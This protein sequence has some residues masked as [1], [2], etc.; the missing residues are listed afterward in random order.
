[1][2][3]C[4]DV[5]I[6]PLS[7]KDITR[8]RT[9]KE[10]T[11]LQNPQRTLIPPLTALLSPS[12]PSQIEAS[13]PTPSKNSSPLPAAPKLVSPSPTPD[14][15]PVSPQHD[16][17]LLPQPVHKLTWKK[18]ITGILPTLQP[19]PKPVLAPKV[20]PKQAST[21]KKA[22][23]QPKGASEAGENSLLKQMQQ[24]F[25]GQQQHSVDGTAIIKTPMRVRPDQSYQLRLHIMGRDTPAP[26]PNAKKGAKPGGL[27]ACAHGEAI[28]VEVRSVLQQG[29]TYVL[30]QATVTIPAQGY[31][32]EVT[33]PMQPHQQIGVV[34]GRRERLHVFF[35]DS[36]RR[37]LYEKPFVVEVFVSPH[38][39]LGREGHQVLT[40]PL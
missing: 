28:H 31:A 11:A 21:P 38:V 6:I 27:S 10:Q 36:E 16:A 39:Q 5:R 15:R 13:T 8:W 9:A 2:G 14:S 29:Y 4:R 17:P 19:E 3:W 7:P 18:R 26:H 25:I 37:P 20:E 32:A 33:I 34:A 35:L 1:R 12:A 23:L 24:L 22:D 40:I 30:Q